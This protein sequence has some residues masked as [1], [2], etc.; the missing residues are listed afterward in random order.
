[1]SALGSGNHTTSLRPSQ[2]EA[3]TAR[4]KAERALAA[5]AGWALPESSASASS[6]AVPGLPLHGLGSGA[7]RRVT[8]GALDIARTVKLRRALATPEGIAAVE[9][10]AL[11]VS[12]HWPG[13]GG[14]AARGS[15]VRGLMNLGN[16]C[17]FNSAVQCLLAAEPLVRYVLEQRHH[18][19][20]NGDNPLGQGGALAATFA[21]LAQDVWEGMGLL[22]SPA[23]AVQARGTVAASVPCATTA[24]PSG[25]CT[26]SG[27]SGERT[28][29]RP[30]RALPAPHQRSLAPSMLKAV[31]ARSAPQFAGFGQQD[32]QELT[33]FL[34]DG[35]HEDLNRVLVKPPTEAPTGDDSAD[36]VGLAARS[37]ATHLKRNQSVIVDLFQGQ[38]RSRL[39]CPACGQVS[40]TFDPYLFLGVPVPAPARPC[41]RVLALS[42]HGAMQFHRT[43]TGSVNASAAASP[44]QTAA[45]GSEAALVGVPSTES[46]RRPGSLDAARVAA[47]AHKHLGLGHG[48]LVLFYPPANMGPAPPRP[49]RAAGVATAG[50]PASPAAPAWAP[51]QSP[52]V[53]VAMVP[54]GALPI[55]GKATLASDLGLIPPA[56]GTA[57]ASSAA[58]A[59]SP[60][61]LPAWCAAQDDL[62]AT[63]PAAAAAAA[64]DPVEG[65]AVHAV[66]LALPQELAARLVSGPPPAPGPDSSAAGLA[67]AT[68]PAA[69]RLFPLLSRKPP[70]RATKPP[71]HAKPTELPRPASGN[72]VWASWAWV[73]ARLAPAPDCIFAGSSL[74]T[75]HRLSSPPIPVGLPLVLFPPLLPVEANLPG[76]RV[77]PSKRRRSSSTTSSPVAPGVA[78]LSQS[79]RPRAGSESAVVRA[80]ERTVAPA[81]PVQCS[82]AASGGPSGSCHGQVRRW[83]DPLVACAGHGITPRRLYGS[84]LAA[85]APRLRRTAL[86]ERFRASLAWAT[87]ASAPAAAS[88]AAE[89]AG[90]KR[91]SA[92]AADVVHSPPEA[93]LPGAAAD[94]L[95]ALPFR[96][97]VDKRFDAAAEPGLTVLLPSD[98]LLPLPLPALARFAGERRIVYQPL[99]VW[100]LLHPALTAA[101]PAAAL[102]A[103]ASSTAPAVDPAAA[104]GGGASGGRSARTAPQGPAVLV[105]ESLVASEAAANRPTVPTLADCLGMFG[106]PERL[107][108]TDA[109]FCP[110]CRDHVRAT[111]ELTLWSA[112]PV[113]VVQLKRFAFSR[114]QRSRIN[115]TVDFPVSGLDMGPFLAGPSAQGAVYDLFA[116][117]EHMGGLGGGHYTAQ[118]RSVADGK[119]YDCDDSMV[120]PAGHDGQGAVTSSAYL[121]FYQRRGS[122][123]Y[124]PP[125][126]RTAAQTDA[127]AHTATVQRGCA[128]PQPAPRVGSVASAAAHAAAL[129]ERARAPVQPTGSPD[130]DAVANPDALG[131]GE[132]LA[133]QADSA[134]TRSQKS[135]AA[136][137]RELAIADRL[138]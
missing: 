87:A 82:I 60:P 9:R 135:A 24:S 92:A 117:S 73:T 74:A 39:E 17:F 10:F 13:P 123:A 59:A 112:P 108:Q 12:S 70:S 81:P 41:A 51:G 6:A 43:S 136:A 114:H 40:V 28:S 62:S 67:R 4:A 79:K 106:A 104:G 84:V 102:G 72:P 58:A 11:R 20:A 122:E 107:G 55:A 132:A 32:S 133:Q 94:L 2:L 57:D 126:P 75:A 98:E 101:V 116:V 76:A 61:P 29:S 56:T 118:V 34:L 78:A 48:Q 96:L 111:K 80:S 27:A 33:A 103:P 85:L 138:S 25:R 46:K 65:L 8:R 5:L 69:G 68:A 97:V 18:L 89:F 121:L 95:P 36:D 3:T 119:W 16:T 131:L 100:V 49:S 64:P 44:E 50:N 15:A 21:A 53:D 14:P 26:S 47:A 52:F 120:R 1:M 37:W 7:A 91:S 77:R 23:D 124:L 115:T 90:D 105:A 54:R 71:S 110:R 86:P 83:P 19:E 130:A 137:A 42:P 45:G 35:I 113:L 31:I 38:L 127:E 125:V 109:W 22:D 99:R 93:V 88:G 128:A 129:Q 63:L 134:C 30:Q 66:A